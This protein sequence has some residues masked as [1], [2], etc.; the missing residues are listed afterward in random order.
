MSTSH[1]RSSTTTTAWPSAE[2][3][4][5]PDGLVLWIRGAPAA[6]PRSLAALLLGDGAPAL[7]DS[8]V[9]DL[10]GVETSLR[11]LVA[12]LGAELRAASAR[13]AT[14]RA[15]TTPPTRPGPNP[16]AAAITAHA[17]TT[18]RHQATLRLLTGLRDWV[19]DLAP[20]T[21]VL[22]EAAEGWA[23]GPRPPAAT[24][25]FVDEDAFLAADP[26]RAEPDQHGGL[27]VAG[28]EAW[29]HGW[30]RDGD[31]DDP[32]A[33]PLEGPDRGGYWSLGYCAPTGDLYA[34]R[35]APHLTR[36]VWLLGT[37]LRTRES[38]RSLL[39]PLTDRM[40]DPNSLVLAAHTIADATARAR[41]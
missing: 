5:R 3:E 35:R 41:S 8:P 10:L 33:L 25:V 4:H 31:D 18:R 40:R 9:D 30:R 26:R 28:I 23:R 21:G 29:G 37:L 16:L 39:D 22:G 34:V 1:A 38:A 32:A 20:S 17:D 7:T 14:A 19:I 2:W 6:V 36:L 11:R 13:V 27:R 12:I 24:T 15:A